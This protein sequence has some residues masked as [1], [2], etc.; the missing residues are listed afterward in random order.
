MKINGE[1]V[2]ILVEPE[3]LGETVKFWRIGKT[4][5]MQRIDSTLRIS[6]KSFENWKHLGESVIFWSRMGGNH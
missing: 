3:E 5:R 6:A 2:E 1:L 4:G